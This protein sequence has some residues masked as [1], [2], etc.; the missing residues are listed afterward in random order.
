MR[1][2]LAP[3]VAECNISA[4]RSIC[5][6]EAQARDIV[7]INDPGRQKGWR[8]GGWNTAAAMCVNTVFKALLR[9]SEGAVGADVQNA[10][11]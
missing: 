8:I 3:D 9:K 11:P 6:D 5:L 1:L 4:A 10:I 2:R 7:A